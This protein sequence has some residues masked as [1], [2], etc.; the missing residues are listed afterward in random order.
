MGL[1]VNHVAESCSKHPIEIA[2]MRIGVIGQRETMSDTSKFETSLGYLDA[3]M[4]KAEAAHYLGVAEKTVER[5]ASRKEVQKNIRYRRGLPPLI[6]F[7]PEDRI[8][9]AREQPPE[10]FLVP[11]QSHTQ[12][13]PPALVECLTAIRLAHEP[14][15]L[16]TLKRAHEASGLP[17]KYLH[18]L[19][20]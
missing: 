16:F 11:A 18:M 4:T 1:G 9:E 14:Y 3:W 6:V 10:P 19:P 12:Q 7:H 15:D 2:C 20:K 17:K 13:L 8:K 5:M